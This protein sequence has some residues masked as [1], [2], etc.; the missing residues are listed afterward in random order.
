M[1]FLV[2][3]A[4]RMGYAVAF[5]LIRS[6][7]VEQVVLAD[8]NLSQ[9]QRVA[10]KLGDSKIT[11]VELDIAKSKDVLELMSRSTV[12]NWLCQLCIQL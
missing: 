5:D 9:L 12:A 1:K 2:L 11:P 10:E 4:G 8:N 7:R 3:G 6:P